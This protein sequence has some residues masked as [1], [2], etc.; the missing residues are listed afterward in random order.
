MAR[1]SAHQ[2]AQLRASEEERVQ[3]LEAR[4]VELESKKI[5]GQGESEVVKQEL[6]RILTQSRQ[7]EAEL[8]TL[9]TSNTALK[10]QADSAAILR[11]ENVGLKKKLESLSDLQQQMVE[12]EEREQRRKDQLEQWDNF[13]ASS[14]LASGS[15]GMK[16]EAQVAIEVGDLDS[17]L[18]TLP[19]AP[20]PISR[21]SWMI[22]IW[23][24]KPVMTTILGRWSNSAYR[25]RQW[26]WQRVMA[27][28][29]SLELYA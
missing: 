12:Y 27:C 19:S 22:E 14:S 11:E 4:V 9:R 29:P 1:E 24:T 25:Q 5:S 28:E 13:L 7:L 16:L 10:K 21:S 18:P 8:S 23:P 3:Q 2:Q 6:H 17:P 20:A 15:E 26:Q